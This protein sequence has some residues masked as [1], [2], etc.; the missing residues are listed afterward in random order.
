[1]PSVY[2]TDP[3]A[4]PG[5]DHLVGV[6]PT[7]DFNVPWHVYVELFK[8]TASVTHITTLSELQAAWS[9]NSILELDSGITFVC[10]VVSENAYRAGA[11]VA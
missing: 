6:A 11:P 3:L 10:S 7:G 5:H 1:M 2:G 4:V 9:S 8:S